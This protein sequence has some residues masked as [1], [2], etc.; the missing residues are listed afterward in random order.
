MKTDYP[1]TTQD[2]IRAVDDM[3]DSMVD[4]FAP[5]KAVDLVCLIAAMIRELQTIAPTALSQAMLNAESVM[6]AAETFCR[7]HKKGGVR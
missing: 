1:A 5:D 4:G 7:K 3:L 2:L 6:R